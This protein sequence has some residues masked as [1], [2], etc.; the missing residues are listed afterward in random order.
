M[1]DSK[2]KIQKI[3]ENCCRGMDY[4]IKKGWVEKDIIG[5][6]KI[7]KIYYT[8]PTNKMDKEGHNV[9]S[10]VLEYCFICATRIYPD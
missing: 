3:A 10:L 7:N 9:I 8:I 1:I 5:D 2:N 4:C 6:T